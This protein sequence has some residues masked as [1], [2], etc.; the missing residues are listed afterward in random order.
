MTCDVNYIVLDIDTKSDTAFAWPADS[1]DEAEEI[2]YNLI[3]G[4]IEIRMSNVF[5]RNEKIMVEIENRSNE[6]YA[7]LTLNKISCFIAIKHL[8]ENCTKD[9]IA[10]EEILDNLTYILIDVGKF[11]ETTNA[12]I[13]SLI[14]LNM[15]KKTSFKLSKEDM[16]NLFSIKNDDK[17]D[18]NLFVAH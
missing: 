16:E 1:I 10:T 5:K 2:I 17:K 11:L 3:Q 14:M 13:S 15:D 4:T 9:E 8:F 12:Q 7:D 18:R 6:I